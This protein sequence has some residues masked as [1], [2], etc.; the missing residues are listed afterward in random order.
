MR[1]SVFLRIDSACERLGISNEARKRARLIFT[2]ACELGV[3]RT[4]GRIATI[5]ASIL[6]ATHWDRAPRSESELSRVLGVS[7][8]TI[9]KGYKELL[10]SLHGHLL[11]SSH[12]EVELHSDS[13]TNAVPHDAVNRLFHASTANDYV[14]R[15]C[16]KL[17]LSSDVTSLA[18]RI[19]HNA[20][21]KGVAAENTPPSQ[22]GGAILRDRTDQQ[23][24]RSTETKRRIASVASVSDVHHH[25]GPKGHVQV[26]VASGHRT[27]KNVTRWVNIRGGHE[28]PSVHRRRD[29]TF[30][31]PLC[32]LSPHQRTTPGTGRGRSMLS[33]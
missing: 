25:K 2:T 17:G 18:M 10:Y 7:S 11:H 15:F 4:G 24:T 33:F 26:P 22:A 27:G 30:M 19:V 20:D 9:T 16:S 12:G 5:A 31:P 3:A 13:A 6:A 28:S 8:A 32:P 21:S 1:R 23:E 14:P 29:Q